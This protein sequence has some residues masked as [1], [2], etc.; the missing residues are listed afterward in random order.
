MMHTLLR[1]RPSLLKSCVCVC[2]WVGGCV[3]VI[4]SYLDIVAFMEDTRLP[5]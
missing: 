3:V 5:E 1:S 4:D 2:V